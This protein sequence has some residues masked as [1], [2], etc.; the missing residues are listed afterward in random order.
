MLI[1]A[2]VGAGAGAIWGA[3][4][5]SC[6]AEPVPTID[7]APC[8]THIWVGGALLGGAVGAGVGTLVGLVYKAL[9]H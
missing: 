3:I 1:G 8:G 2:T 4:G 6:S 5:A 9:K 7:P